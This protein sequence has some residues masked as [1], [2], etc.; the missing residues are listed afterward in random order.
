MNSG[1]GDSDLRNWEAQAEEFTPADEEEYN[2]YLD[3]LEQKYEERKE[4]ELERKYRE[5]F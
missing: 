4:M 3:D 2:A 1:I 5:E